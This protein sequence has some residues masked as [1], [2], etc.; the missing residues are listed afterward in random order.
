MGS[1]TREGLAAARQALGTVGAKNG[2]ATGEDLFSAARV[3]GDSAQLRSAL[4]DPSAEAS[5]KAALVNSVFASIGAPAREVLVAIASNRWSDQDDLLA[6][7]EETAIRAIARS[8][9]ASASIEHEIFMFGTAVASDPELELAVNGKLGSSE[10]KAVLISALF[11]SKASPQTVTIVSKLV[12]QPRGRRIGELLATA[13]S[14]VADE[15]GFAIATVTSAA[16]IN[17]AQRERLR[18][19]LAANYGRDL[20]LNVVVDPSIIG[21]LRVQI[22]DDVIDGSVS[23]RLSELKLQLAG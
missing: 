2:L 1:A 20:K 8:V 5:D 22:G 16:P 15:A 13:A 7:V 11:G 23:T 9:P 4:A 17:T 10:A 12:Q 3:I 6:A 19:A 21:G 18:S 14:I